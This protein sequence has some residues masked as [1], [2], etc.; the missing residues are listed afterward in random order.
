MKNSDN[1][2]HHTTRR[3]SPQLISDG[4]VASY[5]HDISARH[6]PPMRD[7][8]VIELAEFRRHDRHHARRL[9]NDQRRLVAIGRSGQPAA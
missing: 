9:G 2:R 8:V 1:A 3:P 7:R 6:R 5:I 4:V